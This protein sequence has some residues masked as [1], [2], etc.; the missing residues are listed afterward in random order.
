YGYLLKDRI[1]EGN[2]L[3]DAIRCVATG[4][5]ALDP[6]IVEALVRPVIAP[7]GLTPAEEGLLNMVAE[8]KPVKAIAVARGVPPA[9]VEAEVEAMF[10]TLA[11]GVSAGD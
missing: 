1:A 3:A 2:Q 5:T 10:I 8:G 7:G 4:G 11:T 9:V 6:A